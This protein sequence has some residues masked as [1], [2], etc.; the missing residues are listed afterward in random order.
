[1][2]PAAERNVR[3]HVTIVECEVPSTS[4][5]DHGVVKAAY[6]RDSYR[7]PLSRTSDSVVDIFFGIFGHHPLWMKLLLIARNGIAS[8]CGLDAPKVSEIMN[9][10]VRSSYIVGDT[11]GPWPIFELTKNELVAGRDNKHLDFRLSVLTEPDA[12]AG[13]VVVSTICTVHNSFGKV[14]LFFIV[15]FH[16]WGVRWLISRAVGAGRL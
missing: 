9:P 1:V 16:K 10:R 8:F 6:F 3:R 14:Y 11:I 15:P 5:L 2:R 12:E 7:A 4:V 13:S